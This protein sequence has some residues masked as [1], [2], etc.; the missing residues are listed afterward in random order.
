M[1]AFRA[2]SERRRDV[3]AVMKS[4]TTTSKAAAAMPVS[5]R[6]PAELLEQIDLGA[7]E[8]CRSRNGQVTHLLR[9]ALEQWQLQPRTESHTGSDAHGA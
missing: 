4:E 2:R 3:G 9:R 8:E 7:R 1:V 5:F 6:L